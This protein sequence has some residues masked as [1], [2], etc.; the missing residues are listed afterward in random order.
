MQAQKSIEI[1]A[2]P[3]RIW[4]FF[5][6]PAKVLQWFITFRKFEYTSKPS[7]A[8]AASIY[9]EEKSF[10]PSMKLYFQIAEC[11]EN[12]RLALRMV[13]GTGVKSYE[14]SWS[15]EAIPAGSRVTFHEEVELP[16]GI[17]GKLLGS[18][19]ERMSA[20]TVDKMLI[21]L[22]TLVEASAN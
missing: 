8:E 20:A 3:Q 13:S 14:Q 1:A 21:K 4:P 17:I 19:G 7:G 9:V 11:K 2:P 18:I 6:D 5:V 15:L 22:K 10:G 16:F 12:E